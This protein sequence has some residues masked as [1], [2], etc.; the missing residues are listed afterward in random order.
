MGKNDSHYC[1][2]DHL[3]IGI[4]I[5][6]TTLQ[7]GQTGCIKMVLSSGESGGPSRNRSMTSKVDLI[8]S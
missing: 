6:T 1:C 7:V 8:N 5:V 2:F 3:E 4:G